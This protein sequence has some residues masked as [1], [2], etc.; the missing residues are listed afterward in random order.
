MTLLVFASVFLVYLR[1]LPPA[2]APWRDTG[3]MSLASW[4]LSVAHPTSYPLFVLL[5]RAARLIPLGNFA[6]RLN[7]LA[8]AA[9][10]AAAALLF[11]FV[12]RR[13]GV[14]PAL[15]A[16]AWLAF[17]AAFWTVSQVSEMYSLWILCAVALMAL[18]LTA[19]EERDERLWPA[20]CFVAGLLAGNRL[21]LILWAPGLLW[22]ALA[23]RPAA[24][25]ED[26]LW[27]GL[28]FIVFP[29]ADVLTGSNLPF[30]G[31]IALTV[32]WLS[33][34][35]GMTRRLA[36]AAAAGAGGLSIYLFLPV[37]SASGPLLD[38]N[39]PAVLSNFLDSILRTRYGG[40]LDLISK[41]YATGELFGDNLRR[42]GAHLWAGWMRGGV[43]RGPA[44]LARTRGLLVVERARLHFYG[45]H[46]AEP[47][48]HGDPRAS[49][50]PL[51]RGAGLLGG[52]R[53]R[54]SRRRLAR[55][56]SRLRRGRAAVAPLARRARARRP[57]YPSL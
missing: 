21:D 17:N 22:V 5:G 15:A 48:L 8:A 16:V 29:A 13:R 9:G 35:P 4:T 28:A 30:A 51:R 47:A 18:A 49:L 37:R 31:L 23:G 7:V 12:R 11:A 44:A 26:G 52:G 38:W 50:S 57:S 19:S 40:T 54:R 39:H 42:W 24:K 1:A 3:E 20:F 55:A 45:E 14:F 32:L 10:A 2:L 53:R 25:S 33:R 46:A 41:N 36:V 34:G 56:G 43:S 27:A 6:Y